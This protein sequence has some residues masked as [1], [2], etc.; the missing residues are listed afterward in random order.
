MEDKIKTGLRSN[1]SQKK[2]KKWPVTFFAVVQRS[3]CPAGFLLKTTREV[4]A[5]P[6]L[7]QCYSR[8][9]VRVS[10]RKVCRLRGVEP[11]TSDIQAALM[12]IPFDE[13]LGKFSKLILSFFRVGTN[14]TVLHW[15]FPSLKR[16]RW[17][18]G[19]STSH[20]IHISLTQNS[21]TYFWKRRGY[22]N[23]H[24]LESHNSAYKVLFLAR[25]ELF[26]YLR[27]HSFPEPG[28]VGNRALRWQTACKLLTRQIIFYT[29]IVVVSS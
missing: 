24:L 17:L 10:P 22:H 3:C 13:H 11:A 28:I 23:H 25:T 20:F 21:Q 2:I 12:Q 4:L 5:V 9:S 6:E 14:P 1:W 15:Q 29:R 19:V 26:H 7:M 16:E 27:V 8:P 18:T